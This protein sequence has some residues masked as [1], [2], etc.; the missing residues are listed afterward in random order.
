MINRACVF[1]NRPSTGKLEEQ[2]FFRLD[3]CALRLAQKIQAL[4]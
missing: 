2:K 4:E 3:M 1:S